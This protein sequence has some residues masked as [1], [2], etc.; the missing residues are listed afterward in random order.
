MAGNLKLEQG[1][2]WRAGDEFFRIVELER[3]EVVYNANLSPSPIGATRHHV[4]KKEFCRLI[5][6]ATLLSKEEIDEA[7]R[8]P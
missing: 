7:W 5:K 4:S 3:L 6:N 2:M 1:Q 8:T